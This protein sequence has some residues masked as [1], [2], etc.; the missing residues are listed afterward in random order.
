MTGYN[1]PPGCSVSDIPGNRPRDVAWDEW[2]D[3]E[4]D[5]VW[6][7]YL[8]GMSHKSAYHDYKHRFGSN[9]ESA[10]EELEDFKEYADERF[11]EEY[12]ESYCKGRG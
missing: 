8:D 9:G 4:I 12:N 1:L 10:Y 2:F 7:E 11:E 5:G 3:S 6:E